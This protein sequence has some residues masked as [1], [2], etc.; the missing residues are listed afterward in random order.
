MQKSLPQVVIVI[1]VLLVALSFNT[2]HADTNGNSKYSFRKDYDAIDL[3]AKSVFYVEMYD[4]NDQCFGSGSGFIA[5]DEHLFV[6]NE[7]V[8][9][10]ASYIKVWDEDNKMYFIDQFISVDK[11]HDIAMLLFPEGRQYTSLQLD[12]SSD[13]KPGQPV[14]AIGS[15]K[16]FQGSV[17]VGEIN[18][19]KKVEM[20]SGAICIQHTAPSSPGSS[21]GCLFADNG[22]VIGITSAGTS[23]EPILNIAVPIHYLQSLYDNWNKRDYKALD[24]AYYRNVD[25]S[26]IISGRA[27]ADFANVTGGKIETF[28]AIP[29]D[30]DLNDYCYPM[31]KMTVSGFLNEYD[32]IRKTKVKN[33]PAI[34]DISYTKPFLWSDE[35]C[36]HFDLAKGIGSNIYFLP[37]NTGSFDVPITRIAIKC[38]NSTKANA[39]A[40]VAVFNEDPEF[41]ET[42]SRIYEGNDC[43]L[44]NLYAA[45]LTKDGYL[46]LYSGNN[47]GDRALEIRYVVPY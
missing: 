32:K 21:G 19:L 47:S 8:I 42:I 37:D 27:K 40:C 6:T 10:G 46:F 9:D 34:I 28:V 3:A 4:R 35:Y 20:Y 25:S 22:K 45:Y 1:T 16:G 13:L 17:S 36:I 33:A 44:Y 23:G 29:E 41:L 43:E 24:S 12:S 5:F 15:P 2:V 7:H 14:L 30:V 26:A 18:A 38:N 31:E 39:K 11:A